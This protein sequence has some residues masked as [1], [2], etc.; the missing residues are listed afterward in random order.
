MDPGKRAGF[1]MVPP[2][3]F[4]AKESSYPGG[5]GGGTALAPPEEASPSRIVRKVHSCFRNDHHSP[6][7]MTWSSLCHIP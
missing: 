5:G 6:A 7:S 2:M 3:V 1:Q 4:S